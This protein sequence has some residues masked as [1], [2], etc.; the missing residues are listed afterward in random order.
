VY[1]PGWE[2]WL[3]K[4]PFSLVIGNPP[5]GIYK[6][7]Y[8]SY[9]PDASKLRQIEIFFMYYGMK[10]LQKD[11]L[12]IYLTSSSFMRNHT[13]Y[14][15]GKQLLAEI[16]DFVDAYRL[17]KVFRFSDVPTDILIFRRK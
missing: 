10:L 11:G 15:S 5:Y 3:L 16:T 2:S 17:P 4:Y 12:L 9:F 7:K 13:G 6:N 8:S 1:S 14:L